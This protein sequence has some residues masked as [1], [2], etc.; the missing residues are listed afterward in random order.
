MATPLIIT[1]VA[2]MLA[3]PALSQPASTTPVVHPAGP[4]ACCAA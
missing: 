3:I 2:T 1:A 4:P